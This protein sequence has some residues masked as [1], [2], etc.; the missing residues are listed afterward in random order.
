[1]GEE[2]LGDEA[3]EIEKRNIITWGNN[4]VNPELFIG[5]SSLCTMIS[6]HTTQECC[7]RPPID[8]SHAPFDG[9]FIPLDS[10]VSFSASATS[11]ERYSISERYSGG[12]ASSISRSL[13]GKGQDG[14]A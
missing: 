14:G 4:E 10:P 7:R 9:V 2:G 13:C 5:G 12:I 1:M 3:K 6:Y 11:R 8:Q